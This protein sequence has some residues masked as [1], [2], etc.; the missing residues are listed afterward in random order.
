MSKEQATVTRGWR[1][2]AAQV[3]VPYALF[4]V[5]W[6]L[7]SDQLVGALFPGPTENLLANTLKGW[8]FV[9]VTATLLA[10]LLRRLIG[11]IEQQQ[12]AELRSQAAALEVARQSAENHAQLRTLIDTLPD[13]IWLKD[14]AG[15]YLSCN[16]RFELF[17]GA[18][19]AEI[20][21]KTD[22]DFVDA[23]LAAFFRANDQAALAADA[24]RSNE[25]WVTFA[26]DGHR[27]LLN[28]IKAPMRD[29]GGR[30]V[31]VLGIGR[32]I[33]QLHELQERFQA[34]FNASPVAI[35]LTTVE[36]ARILDVNPRFTDLLGWQSSELRGR[37]ALDIG[38][39]PSRENRECW[40]RQ[41]EGGGR[42]RDYQADWLTRDGQPLR[43]SL[44]AD[45]IT[46]G[47]Q[48]Y[49]LSFIID[50]SEQER[51]RDEISQL[52]ERLATAF[53]ATP[54][55]ACITRL[56]DGK[57]VDANDRLLQEYDWTRE[58]LIGRTTVEA[59]LWGDAAD[60]AAM[61]EIIRRDGRLKDFESIG[62]GRDGRR[63]LISMSAEMVQMDGAPHL[64]VFID[65]ITEQRQATAELEK[66]RHHLEEL[67]AARTLELAAA[68]EAAE[69]SSRAKSTFLA[70][71]SHEIRTP[72]NAIIGLTHLVERNTHDPSQL[73]RLT[74]V[75]NAARHLLAIIN[76]IL[77][78]SKIEAGKLEL[79]A[80]DFSLARL[81]DNTSALLIDRIRSRGLQF[82]CTIDPALPSALHGDAL[83]IGQILLNFLSNAT[84]FTEQ[85][86]INID[87]TRQDETA[88]GLI[89]RFAVSDTGI[90]I[91]E[92][93]Q[94]RI[95]DVF[96]QADS[97]TTRRF[98]GTGLG[99]AIARRLA[100]LMGGETGLESTAGAGSTFWFTACLQPAT[101]APGNLETMPLT[102]DAE[103]LLSAW[104]AGNCVLLAE[105]NLINQEVALDLL[106][107]VGLQTDVAVNGK[108]AVEMAAARNY[109]LI[110]MD[111]QM[112]IMDG[113]AATRSIRQA[114][115]SAGRR[116]VP[117]LAM[118]AN[119]FSEDRRRCLEAGMN[120][121]VAK[122]VDPQD[123][124]ATLIKWLPRR[125]AAL[126]GRPAQDAAGTPPAIDLGAALAAVSG[127][128]TSI[129][130]NSVRGRAS[131]YTRL[132]GT[133]VRS[134]ADDPARIGRLL[135]AGQP[136]EALRAAHS[137]K[138]AAGTLGITSIQTAAAA[139]E[140][141]LRNASPADEINRLLGL[142]AS[143]HERLIP[144]I[145]SI[146]QRPT[147]ASPTST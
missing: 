17:F 50:V 48:P 80:T 145:D 61:L 88:A 41:L 82:R 112:P 138:G 53:R 4:A 86:A 97:S 73:D 44:S 64:V 8:I 76:Q 49:I 36:E 87:V 91:P 143:E 46:L 127:L 107:A 13:L 93:Q 31:G 101:G 131:S 67:V 94:G 54:V 92:E 69:E 57:L 106:H 146:L 29:T 63:R 104:H 38:L 65:D 75:S 124:Y 18:K 71:M 129:G 60:R 68:K 117:V 99:L 128:D 96:E 20:R 74:K 3:V 45:I 133:F 66:H 5:L 140:A 28:T 62:I 110:L 139:L 33:T 81:L 1:G 9:A 113:L 95:F 23:D 47:E 21:G 51:A 77:D 12:E 16:K 130:L 59:G 35:A 125:P 109:D 25:E 11:H 42:L 102:D 90:G 122:P 142:L 115:A 72:M 118:T 111:V 37:S 39:W 103:S 10:L 85:G 19:E 30:L 6:I 132:L 135:A 84:K 52:Q 27:E 89:V 26:S 137:L 141:G 40:R 78:I 134:H 83:R 98:G 116:P 126:D 123:L 120:D 34:A 43:V 114:E 2:S 105:D 79:L 24:P 136:G 32:D 58:D 70:N 119:A 56:D 144:V 15:V 55:A 147:A 7:V 22:F 108:K 14:T 121:H 100:Q